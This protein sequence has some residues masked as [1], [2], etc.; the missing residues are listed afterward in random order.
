MPPLSTYTAGSKP[1]GLTTPA[2]TASAAAIAAPAYP[3]S[4]MPISITAAEVGIAK[5]QIDRLPAIRMATALTTRVSPKSNKDRLR[6]QICGWKRH[7]K[8]TS[9]TDSRRATSPSPITVAISS[10]GLV[11]P[12]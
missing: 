7:R 12:N 10:R 2:I 8:A 3:S 1:E 5:V 6:C 11:S 9:S 4:R